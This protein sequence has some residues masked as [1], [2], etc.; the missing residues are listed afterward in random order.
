MEEGVSKPNLLL[1]VKMKDASQSLIDEMRRNQEIFTSRFDH[2]MKDL[3]DDRKFFSDAIMGIHK[4][5][6]ESDSEFRKEIS[7]V[8]K[9]MMWF[10]GL[11]VLGFLS[12]TGNLIWEVI[13]YLKN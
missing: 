2:L 7:G 10:F 9:L 11:A 3:A 12:L 1:E 13:T 4:R 8:Y 5:M 6:S